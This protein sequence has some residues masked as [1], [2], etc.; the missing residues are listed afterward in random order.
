MG[1]YDY[2]DKE[3]VV[4]DLQPLMPLLNQVFYQAWSGWL[5]NPVASKMEHKRVRAD[6]IWN[7]AIALLREGIDRLQC[8]NIN[9][10]TACRTTGIHLQMDDERGGYFIR[11]K[12]ANRQLL[13]SN[14]PTQVALCF[15]DP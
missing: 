14:Y 15:H 8:S 11:C 13:S 4:R 1:L 9:I 2:P 6:V 3:A 10:V 12:K 5:S 7:N